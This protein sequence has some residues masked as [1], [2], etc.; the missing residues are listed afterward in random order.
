MLAKNAMFF[1]ILFFFFLKP[2]SCRK[3]CLKTNAPTRK[4]QPKRGFR[5]KSARGFES[6]KTQQ[7]NA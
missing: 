2:F 5:Q 3:R 6:E 4:R 1:Q 7:A